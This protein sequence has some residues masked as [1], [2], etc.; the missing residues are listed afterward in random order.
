MKRRILPIVVVAGA[1]T[2]GA[3]PALADPGAPGTTFPERPGTHVQT[4]CT[5]VTTGP[6]RGIA[7]ASPT[8]VE[9]LNGLLEDAC[10]G[11]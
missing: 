3:S 6:G 1:M 8:A 11:G 10:F 7:Q 2:I 9:I 4:A 5:V